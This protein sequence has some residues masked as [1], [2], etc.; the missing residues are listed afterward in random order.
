[1]AENYST[2]F[3][4][5]FIAQLKFSLRAS[6]KKKKEKIILERVIWLLCYLVIMLFVYFD[7]YTVITKEQMAIQKKDFLKVHGLMYYLQ[8]L[9]DEKKKK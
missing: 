9:E 6:K 8:R 1:M 4:Q 7:I 5:S 3:C 2:L